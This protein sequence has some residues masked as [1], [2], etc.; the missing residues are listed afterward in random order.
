LA[1]APTGNG[2]PAAG[3]SEA[4]ESRGP[5]DAASDAQAPAADQ[6]EEPADETTNDAIAGDAHA[7]DAVEVPADAVE[8]PAEGG[9]EPRADEE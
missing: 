5:A 9:T 6:A 8:V 4:G 3:D 1:E 7:A 2:E